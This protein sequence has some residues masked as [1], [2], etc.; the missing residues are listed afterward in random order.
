M[1]QLLTSAIILKRTDYSEA[2]RILTLL[3]PD[4]GKISLLAKGV[5]KVKSKLAGGI[6]LFSVSEITYI[7]GRGEVGTL[8]STR[9]VRHYDKIVQDL[10]RTMLGYELIKRLNKV[11]EDEPEEDYFNLLRQAFEALNNF[12][13]PLEFIT[14]WFDAGLLRLSGHTPNLLT[15]KQGNKLEATL[16]YA[17]DYEYT[18]FRAAPGEGYFTATHIKFLRLAFA[19]NSPEVLCKI[20]GGNQLIT[21][22]QPLASWMRSNMLAS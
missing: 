18:A 5:R 8:L 19:G 3:T 16:Q 1:K 2:D 11:T 10:Q 15:D 13:V 14:F 22:C 7:R 21:D 6:E 20:Q 12:E 4:Y 17:F 9:L